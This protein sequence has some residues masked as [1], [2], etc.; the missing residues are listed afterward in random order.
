MPLPMPPQIQRQM[1]RGDGRGKEQPAVTMQA[2]ALQHTLDTHSFN[3]YWYL[4]LF[5]L[6]MIMNVKNNV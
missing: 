3:A 4:F 5:Q 2:A 1:Q 6:T